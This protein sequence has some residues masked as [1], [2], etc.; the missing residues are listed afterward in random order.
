MVNFFQKNISPHHWGFFI[1]KNHLFHPET[2]FLFCFIYF[3]LY[4]VFSYFQL[5]NLVKFSM[6]ETIYR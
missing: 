1:E 4:H 3:P 5:T 6:L 2:P